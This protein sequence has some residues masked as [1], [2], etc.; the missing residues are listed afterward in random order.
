MLSVVKQCH[1][2]FVLIR[3]TERSQFISIRWTTGEKAEH[4]L[5]CMM[6]CKILDGM[7]GALGVIEN[8]ANVVDSL[9]ERSPALRE[10]VI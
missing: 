5:K 6:I 2:S 10:Y 8:M 3:Q 7:A 4:C 1:L 9:F